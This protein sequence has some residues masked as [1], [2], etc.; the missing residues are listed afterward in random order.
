MP[1]AARV[2][3]QVSHSDA[4]PGL[5]TGLLVGA[6]IG[7]AIVATGGGAIVVLAAA[8]TVATS[9][10]LGATAGELLGGLAT[11]PAGPI[12]TGIDTVWIGP[13]R[14]AAATVYSYVDCEQHDSGVQVAEGSATVW[15]GPS[16]WYA[17]RV[18]DKGTCGFTIAEGCKSVIIGGPTAT[19]AG[20]S[21]AGEVPLWAQGLVLVLG[22]AGGGMGLAAKG[23]T[24]WPIVARLGAGLAGGWGG[25]EGGYW[26]GGKWFGE[27]S[28][29]QKVTGLGFGVVGA[30][31]G[32][33][34]A[35][36]RFP[37]PQEAQIRAQQQAA[38][39]VAQREAQIASA[40]AWSRGEGRSSIWNRGAGGGLFGPRPALA[41][42]G[43]EGGS[44]SRWLGRGGS[45][46]Q[47]ERPTVMEMRSKGSGGGKDNYTAK[48]IPHPNDTKIPPDQVNRGK[49][50]VDVGPAYP[51]GRG[52]NPDAHNLNVRVLDENGNTVNSW[53]EVSGEMTDSQKALNQLPGRKGELSSHTEQKALTRGD[54]TE[55]DTIIMTGQRAPCT[56]CKGGINQAVRD[57]GASIYY[58]WRE[59]GVTNIWKGGVGLVKKGSQVLQPDHWPPF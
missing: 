48:D 43:A 15:I 47:N 19:A 49:F 53:R 44:G 46:A 39:A 8:A 12:R 29:G 57:T 24:F 38:Q 23:M 45:T 3:D 21:V 37:T 17:A 50:N 58:Q 22:L 6:L 16:G 59:G 35:S 55:D 26:L 18:D 7:V 5:I 34:L 42:E 52:V 14:R 56:N 20:L 25:A 13:E 10:S 40:D 31:L 36:R 27:G 32:D 30:L 2:D 28:L 33:G 1:E 11:E 9:A 41:T 54:W 4:F 51:T